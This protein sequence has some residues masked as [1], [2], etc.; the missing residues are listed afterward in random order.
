VNKELICVDFFVLFLI[1]FSLQI[2]TL[3]QHSNHNSPAH[4]GECHTG[5]GGSCLLLFLALSDSREHVILV[6]WLLG[7][8]KQTYDFAG[9]GF[10]AVVSLAEAF[11]SSAISLC[12]NC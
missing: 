3:F 5:A 10:V 4:P 2:A 6:C 7:T 11:T 1:F 8:T 12:M 9:C